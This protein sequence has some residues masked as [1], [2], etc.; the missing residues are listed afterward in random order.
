M[1]D[2]AKA[3][4][5][6]TLDALAGEIA[7]ATPIVTVEPA[8][9]AAFRDELLNLFPK[10][11]SARLLSAQTRYFADFVMEDPDR[12]ALAWGDGAAVAGGGRALVQIHC[13]HHAVLRDAGERALLERLGIDFE[14]APSGCC[15]MAGAFGFSA[16]TYGVAMA[17]PRPLPRQREGRRPADARRGPRHHHRGTVPPRASRRRPRRPRHVPGHGNLPFHR[18]PR[19]K[20]A[21]R[22]PVPVRNRPGAGALPA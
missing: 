5:L 19:M 2:T 11:P 9:A 15:G 22:A 12:F 21:P 14:I 8:C 4:W 1:L 20:P 16:E 3:L 17:D 18:P 6:R 7:L 10:D 13:N